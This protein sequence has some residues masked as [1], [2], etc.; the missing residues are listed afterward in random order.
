VSESNWRIFQLDDLL[1][2]KQGMT[3][4]YLEFLRVPALSCGLYQLKAGAKDLQGPHDEDEVYLVLSG[5]GRLRVN[6]E[7][8]EVQRG[9]LLYVRATSEHS[10]FEVEEEMTLLVFFASGGPSS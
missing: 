5:R 9:T 1:E 7:E 3:S 4:P 8:R 10:F 6:D 2:R